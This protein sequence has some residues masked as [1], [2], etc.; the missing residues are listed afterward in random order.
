MTDACV[1]AAAVLA[2]NVAVAVMIVSVIAMRD[3]RRR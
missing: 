3:R 2:V 1:V